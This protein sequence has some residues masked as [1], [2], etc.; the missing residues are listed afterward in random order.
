MKDKRQERTVPGWN[1]AVTCKL[2]CNEES[3]PTSVSQQQGQGPPPPVL[4][5]A[6]LGSARSSRI[7]LSGCVRLFSPNHDDNSGLAAR[8]Q[9]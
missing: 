6:S 9:D 3:Y 7:N 2:A 4:S 1:L 8:E 5:L